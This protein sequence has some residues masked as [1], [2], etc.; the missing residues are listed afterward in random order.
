MYGL[1][2][3]KARRDK[4][5]IVASYSIR[6]H[7]LFMMIA[8]VG[9]DIHGLHYGLFEIIF[10]LLFAWILVCDIL[11]F[12]VF[13]NLEVYKYRKRKKMAEGT[14]EGIEKED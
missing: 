2:Y 3:Y 1:F 12:T 10:L 14:K 11:L 9:A 8:L 7:S 6:M 13:H 5:D 4:Y